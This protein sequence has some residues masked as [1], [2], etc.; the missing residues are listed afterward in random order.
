MN[1][2]SVEVLDGQAGALIAALD[3]DRRFSV[4][5]WGVCD[6]M[7]TGSAQPSGTFHNRSATIPYSGP[8][9]GPISHFVNRA[10]RQ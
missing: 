9:G 6:R 10:A 2:S 4:E 8:H 1:I 3:P 7:K 5:R